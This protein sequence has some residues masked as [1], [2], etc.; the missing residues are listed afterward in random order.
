MLPPID[1]EIYELV[2]KDLREGVIIN[3]FPSVGLV[4]SIVA[5]YVVESL[6]LIQIGAMDSYYFPSVSL[7]RNWEPLSPVRIYGGEVNG[8]KI[9]AFVSEFPPPAPIVRSIAISMLDWAEEQRIS[10]LITPEGIISENPSELN[11]Y[12]VCSTQ[13]GKSILPSYVKRFEE[14]VITGVS[15]VLLTEGKKRDFNVIALLAEAHK[16]FP[17]ARAAAKII[18]VI[19]DILLDVRIDP[20][21]LYE[22]A[23][24]IEKEISQIREA[25]TTIRKTPKTYMYG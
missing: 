17:D 6:G 12:G 3:G 18:E 20:K 9:A 5:N 7:I 13:K 16:D 22:E 21:P 19:N 23:E 24:R 14:G 15:G 25:A 10:M 11:V 4:S 2:K 8:K 1:V